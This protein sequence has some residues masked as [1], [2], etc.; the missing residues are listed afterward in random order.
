[1]AIND[2]IPKSRI[3]LTYR[4]ETN[5]TKADKAIPFRL[6]VMGDFSKGT[7]PK[8][9]K[10][11]LDQ[12]KIRNLDGKNLNQVMKDLGMTLSFKVKNE[13]NP[14]GPDDTL[15]VSLPI[16]SMKSFTPAEIAR[17]MPRVRALLVLR[18]LLLEAQGNMDNSKDFRQLVRKLAQDPAA[19]ASLKTELAPF[20]GVSIPQL[21]AGSV[22]PPA[23][24]VP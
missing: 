10:A 9:P 8:E 16:E 7:T 5:G 2:E 21:S 14:A 22:T 3:T 18:K 6:L 13:V 19:V 15:D 17:N 23:P 11:D 12:R 24:K 20:Q 4:T 1:M